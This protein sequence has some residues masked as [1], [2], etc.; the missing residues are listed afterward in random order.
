[1]NLW[2]NVL[3]ATDEAFVSEMLEEE[4]AAEERRADAAEERRDDKNT[5]RRLK[6]WLLPAACLILGVLIWGI[7]GGLFSRLA[8]NT[9]K[10]WNSYLHPPVDEQPQALIREYRVVGV[11][12]SPYA[13]FRPVR[14]CE[15]NQVGE[16]IGEV[17]VNAAWLYVSMEGKP[18]REPFD[19]EKETLRA[20]VYT[21]RNI[22]SETAVCVKYL[23][24]SE[25]LTLDHYY[26]F[27]NTAAVFDSPAAFWTA[28]NAAETLLPDGAAAGV[29]VEDLKLTS[30]QIGHY[31]LNAEATAAL[32]DKLLTLD[33]T[34][35]QD[36]EEQMFSSC[37]KRAS[38][39]V[40]MSNGL[41]GRVNLLSSGYL[42]FHPDNLWGA[43]DQTFR[44]SRSDASDLIRLIEDR[45]TLDVPDNSGTVTATTGTDIQVPE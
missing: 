1:M 43:A 12:D 11:S 13:G 45:G 42:S 10:Q 5:G 40:K 38:F 39:W 19:N 9:W 14:V 31:S 35:S 30:I 17:T 28:F 15:E 37:E 6:K 24:K 2:D 23:D 20:E 8:G 25:A 41:S 16:K 27:I 29:L 22:A 36:T 7:A 33:G 21:L 44:I 34:A 4:R 32:R 26:T 3:N 18:L